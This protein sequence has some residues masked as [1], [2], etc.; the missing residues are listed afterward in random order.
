M[1]TTKESIKETTGYDVDGTTLALA[2]MMIEAW[3]G[4][5]EESVTDSGDREILSRAV[6]FQA[7]YILGSN[8]DVL[9]QMALKTVNQGESQYV[10]DTALFSPYMSPWAIMT[11]KNLTW[12]GTR[13][14]HTGPIFDRVPRQDWVT[15]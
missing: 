9:Q 10:M 12:M 8:S 15:D 3:I 2:Q 7:V 14:V 6:T 11:C 1:F 5:S 4:R 13:A